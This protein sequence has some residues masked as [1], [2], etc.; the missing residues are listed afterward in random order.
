MSVGFETLKPEHWVGY[1]LWASMPSACLGHGAPAL[2]M[3]A[4]PPALGPSRS[5][6]CERALSPTGSTA[7]GLGQQVK[8]AAPF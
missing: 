1:V 7:R 8:S 5:E 4:V 6:K 3:C 2:G